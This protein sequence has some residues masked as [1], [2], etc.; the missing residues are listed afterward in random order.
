MTHSEPLQRIPDPFNYF[1]SVLFPD[2]ELMILPYNRV[3]KDLNGLE[4]EGFLKKAEE[5]L[6][7]LQK[8]SKE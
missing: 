5:K 7:K 3:V 2:D 8:N 1:L 4:K 6:Q